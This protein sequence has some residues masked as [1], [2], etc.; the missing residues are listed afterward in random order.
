MMMMMGDGGENLLSHNRKI[1][2]EL[3]QRFQ[4]EKKRKSNNVIQIFIYEMLYQMKL[5]NIEKLNVRGIAS[6]NH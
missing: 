5:L 1:C 3:L 6:P 4:N 2:H